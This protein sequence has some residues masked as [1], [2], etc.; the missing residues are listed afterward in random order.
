MKE[1]DAAIIGGG[2]IGGYVAKKIAQNGFKVAVF[3]EHKKIGD[4]LKCAGLVT[5]RVFD[6]LDFSEELVVQNRIKGA[7]IHSPSDHILTIGG[8]KIHALAIDRSEFDREMI[9]YSVEEGADIFLE[10]KVISAKK[11]ENHIELKTSQNNDIDCKLLIGADGAY[12]KTR[13]WFNLPKPTEI[14]NGIGAELTNTKLDPDF[15]E[16]FVGKNIAPG[17]FAWVIPTNENGT[18]AR[19][20]L[21]VNQDLQYPPK[22]YLSNL[23]KNKILSPYLKDAKITQNIGGSI[24]LGPLKKTYSSNALLVGDSAAQVKPTSGGGIYTG[25]LCATHCSSVA[26]ESLNENDFS[27][28]FLK[29]YHKLWM[30][31]IGRELNLGMKFRNISKKLTDN[32]MDKYIE[33]FQN[34]E[35]TEIITKYGDIDYPSKL[36]KPLLKKAPSLIKLLPNIIKD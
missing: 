9:N 2:P 26:I 35:I 31:D 20:G 8:D 4:P 3:E 23:F 33:K 25:L 12:S 17:F 10:N 15:V 34:S 11:N 16:L 27:S 1:Y 30:A 5:P 13:E 36:V 14:L 24:P 18:E 22:Y 29:K 21:C 6:F 32:Q 19:I 7:H 28:N